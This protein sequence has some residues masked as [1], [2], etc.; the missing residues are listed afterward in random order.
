MKP[1]TDDFLFPKI[2]DKVEN[3]LESWKRKYIWNYTVLENDTR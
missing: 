3:F 2:L 1:E